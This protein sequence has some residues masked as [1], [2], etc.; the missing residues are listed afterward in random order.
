MPT[1]FSAIITYRD[2]LRDI[3]LEN[4][5]VQWDKKC[6]GFEEIEEAVWVFFEDDSKEFCDIFS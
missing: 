2:R 6:T 4:I 5:P 3:L 1:G